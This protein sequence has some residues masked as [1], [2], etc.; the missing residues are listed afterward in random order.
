MA[1][2]SASAWYRDLQGNK[3]PHFRR[4]HESDSPAFGL[5][6]SIEEDGMR[7]SYEHEFVDWNRK[8]NRLVAD[9]T[10]GAS[11]EC[12]AICFCLG[13]ASHEPDETP[14]RWPAIFERRGIKLTPFEASNVGFEIDWPARF[15]AEAEGKPLKGV[16][17]RTRL[18]EKLGELVITRYGIEG[19]LIYAIGVEGE[20]SLDL[21]PELSHDALLAKLSYSRE[22]LSPIRRVS[23]QLKLGP[24]ARALIF[25][26]ASPAEKADLAA[27]ARRLKSFPILLKQRR[28]LAEAISS[29]G[30]VQLDQLNAALMFKEHPGIFAAGEMLDWDAPTGGFLIQGCVAEGN[31]AGHG[32]VAYVAETA[33][34]SPS[35]KA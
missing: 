23:H 25:H 21:K 28:P 30:G 10:N 34:I 35:N 8:Q 33:S 3:P 19:S 5:G 31:V 15:L 6:R 9:F 26:L 14:L 32:I 1:R 11:F 18:G 22:N 16:S 4:W 24:A 7:F 2:F 27:L 13:G 20:A 17:L 29:S 12:D